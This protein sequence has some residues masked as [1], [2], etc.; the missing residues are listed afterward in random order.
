MIS[1]KPLFRYMLEHDLTAK[2]VRELCGISK[3]TFTKIN[4]NEEV[5]MTVLNKLCKG[6][7]LSY[8]DICEYIQETGE[9]IN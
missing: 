1:Y 2:M 9:Q 5:S 8:G 6:L 3:N 4:R 7:G